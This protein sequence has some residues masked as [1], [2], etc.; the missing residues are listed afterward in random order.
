MPCRDCNGSPIAG[1]GFC[2]RCYYKHR[3]DGTLKDYALTKPPLKVRFFQF[4]N[5]APRTESGCIEWPGRRIKGKH[6][7]GS[8]SV[9][10]PKGWSLIL[11]AHRV[12]YEIH[13]GPISEGLSVLHT[14]D[15]PPCDNPDHL[16]IGTRD[17]N[18]KDCK[19]K[20]RNARG[21]RNGHARLVDE[22][23]LFIRKSKLPH[24][25]LAQIFGV[26]SSTIAGIRAKR[27][28]G[29]VKRKR[30]ILSKLELNC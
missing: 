17:D 26:V 30:L 13:K 7:Y 4:F 3:R 18:N 29:H 12:S 25:E 28:W 14:C 6:N 8:I 22:D 21:A 20:G 24:A 1:R 5:R 10:S 9:E 15:N 2:K 11:R 27:R 16:F 23:I 19:E